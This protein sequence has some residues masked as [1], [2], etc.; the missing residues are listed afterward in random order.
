MLLGG[1]EAPA[2]AAKYPTVQPSPNAPIHNLRVP[3]DL[4]RPSPRREMAPELMRRFGCSQRNE[5]RIVGNR[6][7]RQC[8]RSRKS[9]LPRGISLADLKRV[10]Q[11][12]ITQRP[13]GST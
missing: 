10:L 8:Q 4:E 5:L 7:Q 2:V 9:V 6:L 13:V 3:R 12:L 1:S 11:K